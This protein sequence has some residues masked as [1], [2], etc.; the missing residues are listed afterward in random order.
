M[1][2]KN[3]C[4]YVSLIIFFDFP[5]KNFKVPCIKILTFLSEKWKSR[6]PNLNNFY[7]K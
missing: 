5:F 7:S 2:T 1:H 4:A 6:I 3:N